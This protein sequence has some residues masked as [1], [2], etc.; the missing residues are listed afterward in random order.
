MSGY[1]ALLF[2]VFSKKNCADSVFIGS[3][4]HSTQHWSHNRKWATAVF[5][6]KNCKGE[7]CIEWTE[8]NYKQVGHCLLNA[9]LD[10]TPTIWV[11]GIVWQTLHH[12]VLAYLVVVV[13]SHTAHCMCYGTR[14]SGNGSVTEGIEVCMSELGFLRRS[15][16][17]SN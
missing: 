14:Q 16:A 2:A 4:A 15:T 13:F 1:V 5:S 3:L 9:Y 12:E 17:S 11:I 7:V 10:V 6:K 8:N